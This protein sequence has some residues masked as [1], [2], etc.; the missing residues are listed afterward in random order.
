MRIL[1]CAYDVSFIMWSIILITISFSIFIVLGMTSSNLEKKI[2]LLRRT[3]NLSDED[4]RVI[5]GKQPALLHYSADRNLAPTI[6]FL[7]RAL[8]LS[9]AELRTVIWNVQA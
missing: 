5:L 1:C 8:D 3:M 7:V 6:L 9:K 2:S 4:I